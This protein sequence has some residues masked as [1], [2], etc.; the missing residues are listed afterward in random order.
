MK[1]MRSTPIGI[2]SDQAN[3]PFKKHLTLMVAPKGSSLPVISITPWLPSFQ[4]SSSARAETSCALHEACLNYGF[5]YLDISSFASKSETDEIEVLARQF[6][7]LDQAKKDSIGIAKTDG[8]RGETRQIKK[9][10]CTFTSPL[11]L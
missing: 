7:A 3:I 5:F 6:F 8:A 10:R 4:G 9:Y 11:N 2:G 1:A